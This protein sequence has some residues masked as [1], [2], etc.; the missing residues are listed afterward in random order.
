MAGLAT[1]F[2]S[3][4]QAKLIYHTGILGYNARYQ[5]GHRSRWVSVG[6]DTEPLFFNNQFQV[7]NS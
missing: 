7:G 6:L 4:Q 5:D 2:M 1:E 3:K